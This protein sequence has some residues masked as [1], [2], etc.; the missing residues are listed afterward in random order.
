MRTE[1]EF[2][3]WIRTSA[4]RR[5]NPSQRTPDRETESNSADNVERQ[6]QA[7]DHK[8]WGWVIYRCTYE[9][10]SQWAEFMTRLRYYIE[11]TLR[12]DNALD[13]LPSLDYTIFEDRDKFDKAHPSVIKDHFQE[14]VLTAPEREQGHDKHSSLTQRYNYCLHV[15]EAALQSVIS[16]PAPPADE[17]GDGFVNLVCLNILGGM[18]PEHT[19]DRDERD[20]CWMRIN[21]QYLMVTWYAFFRRQGSWFT[22]YMIPP[23]I[24]RP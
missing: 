20:H 3:E 2:L 16:G 18:R 4:Q 10:D 14:W 1:A 11:D 23:E 17:P 21:Y 22:A 19:E 6:L 15:D 12:F 8:I 24:S 9:C 7:D 13:M 5:K